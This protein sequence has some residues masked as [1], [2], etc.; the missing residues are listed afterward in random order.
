MRIKVYLA[1]AFFAASAVCSMAFAQTYTGNKITL[2]VGSP[3]GGGYDFYSRILSRHMPKYL[4]GKPSI[5]VQNMPGA[6]SMKAAEYLYSIAPKDGSTF[7]MIFPG[8]LVEPLFNNKKKFRFEP[9]QFEFIGS[10]DSGIRL[11]VTSGTSRIKTFE[12]AQK[13]PSSFGGS[14]P[15]SSTTDYAVFLNALAGAKF[16][17]VNG[18]KGSRTTITAMERGELDGLCGLDS[19]SFQAMKPDWFNNPKLAHMII[20]TSIT[21]DAALEKLGVPSIW[22]YVK[23]ENRKIA[24]IILAQQEF[25]R[26]YLAPPGTSAKHLALLRTAFDAA[27]KDKDLLAETG[28]AKLSVNAKNAATVAKLIKEIYGSPKDLID[29]ARVALR[30][31]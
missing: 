26:P 25:H 11:C 18:Y 20:Q 21:P 1:A 15:G 6:G 24:E 23:G 22:K 17:I 5:I 7:G 19:G 28:K 30:G 12:D 4:P 16:K 9:T 31:Q 10:I 29:K 27:V 3:P 2:I 8:A 14:G 13:L